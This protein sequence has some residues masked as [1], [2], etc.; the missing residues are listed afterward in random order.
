MRDSGLVRAFLVAILMMQSRWQNDR[1]E[2]HTTRQ[3]WEVSSLFFPTANTGPGHKPHYHRGE[4]W[5]WQPP[6][7]GASE[8]LPA[9]EKAW[10]AVQDQSK[11]GFPWL[12]YQSTGGVTSSTRGLLS[13]QLVQLTE[14]SLFVIHCLHCLVYIEWGGFLVTGLSLTVGLSLER[15]YFNYWEHFP[16]EIHTNIVR[17]RT[18][19]NK[20]KE[21]TWTIYVCV[22]YL[23][24][25]FIF[26]PLF[27]HRAHLLDLETP[28]EDQAYFFVVAVPWVTTGKHRREVEDGHWVILHFYFDQKLIKKKKG[29]VG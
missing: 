29:I 2:N 28:L 5:S 20:I 19:W 12:S 25:S 11:E 3:E 7:P 9:E 22:A 18:I 17:M 15:L 13:R 6:L 27:L 16:T 23:G 8:A 10:G 14:V 26:A 4:L 24:W 21:N 1:N